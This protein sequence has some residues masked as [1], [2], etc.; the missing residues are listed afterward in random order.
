MNETTPRSAAAA[1]AAVQGGAAVS[2]RAHGA[3]GDGRSDDTESIQKA[4]DAAP[5]GGTV[6]FPPG[7][8]LVRSVG[9]RPGLRYRG[10]RGAILRRPPGQPNWTRTFTTDR[11][12]YTYSGD[13]DSPLTSFEGITFDGDRDRQG[14]YAGYER[15]QAHLLFLHADPA[16]RGRLKALVRDCRFRNSVADGISVYTNVDVTVRGCAAHNCFRGGF[17]LTGGHSRAAVTDFVSTGTE[18][19]K[20]LDIEVDGKGYGGTLAVDVRLERLRLREGGFDVAVSD[21]SRVKGDDI[22]AGAPLY[23]FGLNSAMAF[24]RSRFSVGACDTYMNR[25]VFPHEVTFTDCEL[26]VTRQETGQPYSYFCAAEV[27]WQHPIAPTQR[28]Q[29]LR[30]ERCRFTRDQS[31]RPSDRTHAVRLLSDGS[32]HDNRLIVKGCRFDRGF[33]EEISGTAGKDGPAKK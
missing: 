5:A 29:R 15:E 2:V 23:L 10:E 22:L 28:G 7:V 11:P 17:V 31:L 12:G 18:R 14:P 26:R 33:D 20:G 19:S 1:A 27:W 3:R 24:T 13:A 32:E 30:F 25:I 6:R 9:V 16:R 4:I 8:Y 21:G